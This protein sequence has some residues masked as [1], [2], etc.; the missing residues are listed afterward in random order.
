MRSGS[1]PPDALTEPAAEQ[2]FP[3]GE[4]IP[5]GPIPAGSP[6]CTGQTPANLNSAMHGEAFA[7]LKYALYAGHAQSAGHPR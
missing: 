6:R 5:A 1:R 2:Q 3:V 7:S 4:R